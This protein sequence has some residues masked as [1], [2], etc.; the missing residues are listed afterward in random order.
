V[1]TDI[2]LRN[3]EL[4]FDGKHSPQ[5]QAAIARCDANADPQWKHFWDG[6]VLAAARKQSEITSDD[7]LAEFETLPRPPGTH[8]LA[9]IGPAMKRAARMGVLRA[10]DRTVRSRRPEK[11]GNLHVV[12]ESRVYA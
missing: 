4:D 2:R 7:V 3:Y 5:T 9:A 8:N 12:W 11:Q 6:C 10:T 1:S